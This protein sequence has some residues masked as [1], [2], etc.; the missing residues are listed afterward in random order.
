MLQVTF[1]YVPRKSK[2]STILTLYLCVR[3]TYPRHM[4]V[5]PLLLFPSETSLEVPG[6]G[7]SSSCEAEKDFR[8]TS[9]FPAVNK[10][11]GAWARDRDNHIYNSRAPTV[12]G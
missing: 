7:P 6:L 5:T 3:I 9:L 2:K 4:H 11:V 10:P 8:R 12:V 1:L